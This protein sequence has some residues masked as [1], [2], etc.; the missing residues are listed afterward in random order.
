MTKN[1]KMPDG[2]LP[3]AGKLWKSVLS[4]FDLGPG[5]VELLRV[6]CLSLSEFLEARQGLCEQGLTFRTAG[7]QI[8]ANPLVMIQKQA[9]ARFISVMAALG[10]EYRQ[11]PKSNIGRPSLRYT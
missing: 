3:E 5:E 8:K 9:G 1:P 4:D 7:G 2:L 11:D 10:L 6:A